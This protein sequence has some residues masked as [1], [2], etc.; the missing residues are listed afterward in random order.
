M[1]SCLIFYIGYRVYQRMHMRSQMHF[2]SAQPFITDLNSLPDTTRPYKYT[3]INGAVYDYLPSN[4]FPTPLNKQF[5]WSFWIYVN[6]FDPSGK[7]GNDW[8]SYRFG[9]YKHV[10]SRGDATPIISPSGGSPSPTG[11]QYPGFWLKP[12]ENTLACLLTLANNTLAEVDLKDIPMNDW[13]NVTLVLE[14]NNLALYRNGL[15]EQSLVLP[16]APLFRPNRNVYVTNG[17]GFAGQLYYIQFFDT[18][19][20]PVQIKLLYESQ[21]N[22]I[23]E[24]MRQLDMKQKTFTTAPTPTTNTSRSC[25]SLA[26]SNSPSRIAKNTEREGK[27]DLNT[28]KQEAKGWF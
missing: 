7:Q 14:E 13:F 24:F 1:I 23:T 19:L 22:N 18:S 2:D 16:A 6:G 26:G 27:H 8:G 9:E 17:G 12:T 5:T 11:Y 10:L 28:F 3:D 4:L 21:S 20:D 15:L 25:T